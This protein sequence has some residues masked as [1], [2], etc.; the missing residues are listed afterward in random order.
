MKFGKI[1]YRKAVDLLVSI[2]WALSANSLSE[3]ITVKY[4]KPTD[5]Q[6]N[7]VSIAACLV[8]DLIHEEIDNNLLREEMIQHHLILMVNLQSTST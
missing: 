7:K 4:I 8:N 1:L 3:N 6:S 2:S 5:K